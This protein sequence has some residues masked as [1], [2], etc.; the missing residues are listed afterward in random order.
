MGSVRSMAEEP[1]VKKL[2]A[3]A[4]PAPSVEPKKDV[5]EE[6]LAVPPTTPEKP[7]E[8]SKALSVVESKAPLPSKFRLF[9]T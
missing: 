9:N 5:A 1:V 3:E 2:E 8:E 7:A 6:K 4:P